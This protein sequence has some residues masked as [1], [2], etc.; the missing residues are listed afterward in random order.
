MDMPNQWT[1]SFPYS[2]SLHRFSIDCGASDPLVDNTANPNPIIPPLSTIIDAATTC[3]LVGL[4]ES[5]SNSEAPDLG[6]PLGTQPTTVPSLPLI[7]SCSPNNTGR[8]ENITIRDND[9]PEDAV[10]VIYRDP[11]LDRTTESNALPFVLQSYARWIN[12]LALDP[13]KVTSIARDFVFNHFEGGEQSRWIIGLLANIGSKVGSTEL[14]EGQPNPILSMLQIAV[15]RRIGGAKLRPNTKRPELVKTLDSVI[16]T[17]LVHFFVGSVSE[18]MVL[19][20]EAAPIFRRLCSEPLD[21]PINLPPL[22]HH[23]LSCLRHYVHIDILFSVVMDIPTSF[24]YET[25]IPGSQPPNPY[26]LVPA[27]HGDGIIQWLHGTPNEMIL[28]FAKMKATR[29]DGITPNGEMVTSL[30]REVCE[31]PPF[32]GSSSERFLSIMRSV[33]HECWRQAAYIYLYMAVCGDSSDTPRVKEAF[34]R[35]MQLLNSTQPGRLPDEFLILTLQLIYPAAQ[36]D[37][38]RET[39]KHRLL[40][41]SIRDRTRIANNFILFVMNDV[42]ARATAEERPVVWS[43]LTVSRDRLL[44]AQ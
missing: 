14:V 29:Q 32:D 24:A 30:E 19:R 20:Q 3:G 38:D 23:P 31:L 8:Q 2:G 28:L 22:L 10:S 17:M 44:G 11:V 6:S 25:I 13:L 37:R 39:I 9:R 42:W 18:A 15:R 34:K 4:L 41:F 5:S 21:G 33:V 16:E 12:R 7:S 40:R 36:R 26:R 35:Y 1:S 27:S 43:D